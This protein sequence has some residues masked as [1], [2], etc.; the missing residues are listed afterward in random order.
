MDLVIIIGLILINGVFA[1]SELA[2]VSARRLRLERLAENGSRGARAALQLADSP[3]HFLSTVQVG[4]TVIGIF[5]GA[6]GEAS[7]VAR[8]SPYL[9][10]LPV[11]G[12]YARE[13][14]LGVVVLGITVASIIFGE[15]VPKRIALI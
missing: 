2:L 5:N 10:D 4:I 14:A 11:V 6:I 12:P 9:T 8:L 13:V 7:L 1:M 15:R 3:S